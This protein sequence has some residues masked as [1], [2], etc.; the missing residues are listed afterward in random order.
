MGKKTD[1][2]RGKKH[3]K[4]GRAAR[5]PKTAR[6]RISNRRAKNKTKRVLRSS[7]VEAATIYAREHGTT[8]YLLS[9]I[10]DV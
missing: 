1:Q 10:G 4:H 9:L 6:Y 7:G 5:K 3:R 8:S 2:P